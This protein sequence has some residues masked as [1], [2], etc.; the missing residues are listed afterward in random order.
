MRMFDGIKMMLRLLKRLAF[1]LYRL[2]DIR[3]SKETINWKCPPF[4]Q[5][6]NHDKRVN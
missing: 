3:R 2:Y 5:P 6:V 4:W 1:D